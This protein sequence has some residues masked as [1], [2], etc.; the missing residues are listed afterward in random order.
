MIQ[1]VTVTPIITPMNRVDTP[2]TMLEIANTE[3]QDCIDS[4][5]RTVDESCDKE[6][7]L[8]IFIFK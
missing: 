5:I 8:L 1:Y 3:E 7:A 2:I 4:V 6:Y